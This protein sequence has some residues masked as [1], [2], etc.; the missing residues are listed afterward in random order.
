[1]GSP[2]DSSSDERIRAEQALLAGKG[3][4]TAGQV[5]GDGKGSFVVQLAVAKD[6]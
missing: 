2:A 5:E 3:A 4:A 1:L 6:N